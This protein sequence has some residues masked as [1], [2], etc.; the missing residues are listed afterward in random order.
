MAG[1]REKFID[2]IFNYCDRW[3]ERCDFADRC[4]LASTEQRRM[5]RRRRLG[6]DPDDMDLAMK[7]VVRDFEKMRRLIER[8]AKAQG[9]DVEEILH[10]DPVINAGI[11]QLEKDLESH[12]VYRM[13]RTYNRLCGELLKQC[14]GEFNADA[15]D[16]RKRSQ[17]MNVLPEA[18]RFDQLREAL[19]VVAWDHTLICAK[20]RRAVSG[21]LEDA[22]DAAQLEQADAFHLED[23]AGSA[24]VARRCLIRSKAALMNLY[25]YHELRRDQIIELLRLADRL[26]HSLE[27]LVPGCLTFVWPPAGEPPEEE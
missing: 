23:A 21:V 25:E 7:D 24:Y 2:S 8:H 12:P 18:A 17:Y 26:Q 1:K 19:D 16:A 27:E 13:A 9:I 14:G 10:G 5:A 6:Q 3:C 11:E 4:R 22:Q 20:V 15:K